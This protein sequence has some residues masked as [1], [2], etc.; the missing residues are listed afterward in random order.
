MTRPGALLMVVIMVIMVIMVAVVV[1][2][3]TQVLLHSY[4]TIFN[5]CTILL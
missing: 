1:V 5:I 4:D 3:S 2:C